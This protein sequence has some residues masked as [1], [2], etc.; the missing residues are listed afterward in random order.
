MSS[1]KRRS[2]SR[3]RSRSRKHRNQTKQ[4]RFTPRYPSPEGILPD[5]VFRCKSHARKDSLLGE[6]GVPDLVVSTK[7]RPPPQSHF[8][9][10]KTAEQHWAVEVGNRYFELEVCKKVAMSQTLSDF[11]TPADP[12]H[13]SVLGLWRWCQVIFPIHMQTSCRND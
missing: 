10:S 4:S 2:S 9:G 12:F 5:R 8:Q 6:L 13:P 1:L 11:E 3:S 7:A